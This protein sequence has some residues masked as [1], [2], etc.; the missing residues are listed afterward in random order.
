MKLHSFIILLALVLISL[1]LTTQAHAKSPD[2]PQGPPLLA[3]QVRADSH[4][5][6]PGD[7]VTAPIYLEFPMQVSG[8]PHNRV[9]V[10]NLNIVITYD[11]KI[12]KPAAKVIAGNLMAG[13]IFLANTDKAGVIQIAF[14][15]NHPI[16]ASGKLA[17]INFR[18]IGKA[19][20]N[21]PLAIKITTVNDIN[22]NTP[23]LTSVSGAVQ[24]TQKGK[25]GDINGNGVIDTDDA[26][27][28]LKMSVGLV[29]ENLILDVDK[30]NSVTSNDARMLLEMI[31]YKKDINVK[32]YPD[33]KKDTDKDRTVTPPSST[34]TLYEEYV[35]AYNHLTSLMHAGQTNTPEVAKAFK[36]YKLAKAKYEEAEKNNPTKIEDDE[37]P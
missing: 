24:I 14:A 27:M 21:S 11:T 28:A 23:T 37:T 32:K 6:K 16:I 35:K 12:I 19:G 13:T 18:V 17:L 36:D 15:A 9:N 30:S 25:L 34:K 33:V 10:S 29:K 26:M 7:D 4:Q 22:G 20:Q 3:P 1:T 5:V 2:L 31:S 8:T